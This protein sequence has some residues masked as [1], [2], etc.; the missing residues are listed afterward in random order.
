[1]GNPDTRYRRS[2]LALV[3]VGFITTLLFQE[4]PFAAQN[5]QDPLLLNQQASAVP[6]ST[7]L[8]TL[9]I[10]LENGKLIKAT[11]PEGGLIRVEFN[12][13]SIFGLV[14]Y[15]SDHTS[16]AVAVK[17]LRIRKVRAGEK[18]IGERLT[19]LETIP[20]TIESASAVSKISD[21]PLRFSLQLL[22]VK[23]DTD[24]VGKS[25]HS[26]NGGTVGSNLASSCCV[27][28]DGGPKTCACAVE[29]SCGS[30][31]MGTCCR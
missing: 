6:L 25:V 1:M 30:C 5:S 20:I 21:T 7:T 8:I 16:G 24:I 18:A 9:T 13:F 26:Q 22:A 28:C 23:Q 4:N 27:S 17:I 19:E 15:V 3:L 12:E 31:C 14:P 2:A 29:M 10:T 11:Q